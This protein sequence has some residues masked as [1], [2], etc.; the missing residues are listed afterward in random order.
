MATSALHFYC[1][2]CGAVNTLPA[3]EHEEVFCFA[4]GKPLE[5]ANT[6]PATPNGGVEQPL[7]D[8][9]LNQ[10]YLVVNQVGTGG[11]GAVYRAKDTLR[12]DKIVALKCINLR[13]LKPHEVIEATDTFN[14]EMTLLSDLSHSNLP[15][16]YDHFTDAEHWYLVMD[17]IGGETLEEYVKHTYTEGRVPLEEALDIGIQLCTVLGYLHTRQPAIIFRDVKPAN[18]MHTPGGH[19]YL[20]DF[21]IARRFKPGQAK[22]TI[23]LGSPGYAAP[24]QY[25]K[26]Q[27]TPQ[28]DLYGLGATLHS[29]LTGSDPSENP[30][31]LYPLSAFNIEAPPELEALIAQMLDLDAAKRPASAAFV[32][33]QLQRIAA[34][35]S[36]SR[37]PVSSQTQSQQVYYVPPGMAG[38]GAAKGSLLQ[39]LLPNNRLSPP[40]RTA[41][42]A[43]LLA[44][45]VLTV[46]GAI[47]GVFSFNLGQHSYPMVISGSGPIMAPMQDQVYRMPVVGISD[48]SMLDPTQATNSQSMTVAAM[49]YSGLV[50]LDDNSVAMPALAASW[51][52]SPD[53]ITYTFHL[54]PGL[55]F[56]D[57]RSLTSND[58]AYSINRALQPATRSDTCM[59]YLG[60]IQD[61]AKLHAGKIR[62]LIGDSL[63][64]PDPLTMIIKLSAPAPYF[65]TA[66]AFPCS[67]VVENI[68]DP[69]TNGPFVSGGETGP[70]EVQQYIHG[71]EIDVVPNPNYDGARPHFSKVIIDLFQNADQSYKA[72]LAGKLDMTPV[73]SDVLQDATMN[74]LQVLQRQPLPL[75]YYFGMN[76]LEKP[77]DNVQIRQALAL[78]LNKD[79][80]AALVGNGELVPTNHFI[81]AGMPG[82]NFNLNGPDGQA[83]TFGN[84]SQAQTL[85]KIGMAAEGWSSVSQIPPIT[86]TYADNSTAMT[87]EINEAIQMWQSILGIQVRAN[88]V[89]DSTLQ[90][91]ISATVNNPRGLQMWAASWQIPYPDPEAIISQAFGAQSPFNAVNYGATNVSD[92]AAQQIVQVSLAENEANENLIRMSNYQAIEQQLANDVAWIPMFQGTT[93]VLSQPDVY[94][95]GFKNELYTFIT[96]TMWE[97]M[98]IMPFR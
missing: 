32:K 83:G 20:I 44:F 17:F 18:I 1:A 2:W 3:N 9:L 89:S 91:D 85:L 6:T 58:V 25:G 75:L 76:Y 65:L 50:T 7:T 61:A 14:R 78:A 95:Y 72:F 46:L 60:M 11:Y 94:T 24:E 81:P 35:Q 96:P 88:P 66:L 71:Q 49:L 13:D 23:A 36:R 55:K 43:S 56:S 74:R 40:M 22:D 26:A 45:S 38:T 79:A 16:V 48:A 53:N 41:V 19:L 15:R 77:F 73:P 98:Y 69:K 84:P 86:F 64:T 5:T 51:S 29:L 27:T 67:Y 80:I 52:L 63:L 34:E 62:T 82:F 54:H 30:F 10:R 47:V 31:H 28:A 70:F 90:H 4:C 37:Y 21:G 12:N 8:N 87:N 97:N 92:A 39:I 59:T 68:S 93:Q 57:G 42:N 33:Q